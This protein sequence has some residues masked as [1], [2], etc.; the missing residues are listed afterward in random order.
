MDQRDRAFLYDMRDFICLN[1]LATV[2]ALY[3]TTAEPDIITKLT[4]KMFDESLSE[5]QLSE[6]ANHNAGNIQGIMIARIYAELFAGYEDIGA[7]G[8]AIQNR[9]DGGI[10]RRYVENETRQA[11]RFL[12][13]VIDSNIPEHPEVTLDVVLQIPP[14]AQFEGHI[15]QEQLNLLREYYRN[16]PGFLYK[17]AKEYQA[18]RGD[19]HAIPVGISLQQEWDGM[20][21]VILG[22]KPLTLG[23]SQDRLSQDVFNRIKH[24]FLVTGNLSAYSDPANSRP[25]EFVHLSREQVF[26]DKV[27]EGMKSIARVMSDFASILLLLDGLGI[28]V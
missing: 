5:E 10:F 17:V 26:T 14:V 19:A 8:Q 25:L 22:D 4:M 28:E 7:L 23:S 27:L 16:I 15:P 3:R 9:A 21:A 20:V 18:P 13:G 24:Q 12:Q 11:R 1:R 2:L 6:L